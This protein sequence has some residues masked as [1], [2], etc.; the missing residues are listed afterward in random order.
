MM[1]YGSLDNYISMH[2]EKSGLSQN[3][4]ALLVGL[5]GATSIARYEKAVRQP[6][7]RT[8]VAFEVVL[9]EPL[10]ALFAGE[11]EYV[12]GQVRA[13]ARALLESMTDKPTEKNAQ[14]LQTLARLAHLEDEYTI[15]WE[16]L[17]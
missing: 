2:R 12:R 8:L 16:D 11:C 14:K 13:R 7:L 15:R 17:Q 9:D 1:L 3:E 4:L 10:Q 5:E 6:E